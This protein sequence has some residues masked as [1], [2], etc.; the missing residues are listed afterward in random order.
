LYDD[1]DDDDII[2]KCNNLP[3]SKGLNWNFQAYIQPYY[4]R[5]QTEQA[6]KLK[7]IKL[8]PQKIAILRHT[9]FQQFVPW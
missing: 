8:V 1:D 2:N 9:I 3:N 7:Q 6:D 4:C 5:I